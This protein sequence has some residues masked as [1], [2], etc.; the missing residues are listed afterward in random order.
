VRQQKPSGERE[1][2]T[3][4][5]RPRFQN[6]PE[7]AG[8]ERRRS[9][10]DQPQGR[11]SLLNSER[12]YRGA[13]FY[14]IGRADAHQSIDP[15]PGK[16]GGG[17]RR[18]YVTTI[19]MPRSDRACRSESKLANGS[20]GTFQKERVD[21]SRRRTGSGARKSAGEGTP[22]E[23]ETGT[24]R[25]T[26]KELRMRIGNE[27]RRGTGNGTRKSIGDETR[28]GIGEVT[29]KAI[30][31]ETHAAPGKLAAADGT[32]KLLQRM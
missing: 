32:R 16:T 21:K 27:V 9:S 24:A 20:L 19:R 11:E 6:R 5:A 18:A 30:R 28:K 23:L 10:G 12:P 1:R 14:R 13:G 8:R 3:E 4:R 17:E 15:Q 25:G 2:Q 22:G 26:V 29:R 31:N 7:D